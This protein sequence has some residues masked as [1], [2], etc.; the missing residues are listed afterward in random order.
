MV[1]LG[2]RDTCRRSE[3]APADRQRRGRQRRDP[4]LP[5]GKGFRVVNNFG[6]FHQDIYVPP[7]R[8]PPCSRLLAARPATRSEPRPAL[9]A[10]ISRVTCAAAA[11]ER[12]VAGYRRLRGQVGRRADPWNGSWNGQSVHRGR[13]VQC[14]RPGV[15]SVQPAC[16][17]LASVFLVMNRSSVRFRQ[18]APR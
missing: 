2:R 12:P 17:V 15:L 18:A 11:E 14:V 5:A 3:P 8:G 16:L 13:R 6:G 1:G 9:G 4:G 7:Q 10:A